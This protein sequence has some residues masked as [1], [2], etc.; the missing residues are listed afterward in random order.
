MR[1][2]FLI[3]IFSLALVS[4]FSLA[5]ASSPDDITYPIEE[6]GNCASKE[7]CRQYCSLEQNWVACREFAKKHNLA[8]TEAHEVAVHK[9]V[10]LQF[11]ITE[12]G[13]CASEE[14]CRAYCEQPENIEVCIDFAEK[15]GFMSKEDAER[16]KRMAIQFKSEGFNGPGGCN[17]PQSCES[18]CKENHEA[19]IDWAVDNGHMT[20]EEADRAKKFGPNFEGPG[21]CKGR[22]ACEAY[23]E[24]NME[25]C[26][27]WAEEN[28][29]MNE[30][31]AQAAKKFITEGGPGGCKTFK[32]CRQFCE[33]PDN[34][35]A[36]MDW[37]VENGFM[38][39]EEAER[40]KKA[41]LA[42]QNGPG[43]CSGPRECEAYCRN[44]DNMQACVDWACDNGFMNE[45]QCEVA[46]QYTQRAFEGPGG[47]KTPEA[48]EAYCRE[49]FQTCV[50][51]AKSQRAGSEFGQQEVQI[52]SSLP[53]A[54]IERGLGNQECFEF[55]KS[56]PKACF[57]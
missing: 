48:C 39:A 27:Q 5:Y 32:E 36:C 17:S 11:P 15:N 51:W 33:N 3:A 47:C 25:A 45:Q 16:A 50:D 4:V 9:G 26:L 6:L 53:P 37:A 18:Y 35:P 23:C 21:G 46:K 41:M 30:K 42:M 56:D 1:Q 55:C 10:S 34:V 2:V 7:D 31:E 49:N 28:G 19:C 14:E 38:S 54:C 24:Q 40:A 43:G 44:P 13:N 22:E 20:K 12:L 52:S 57:A 8:H 29:M